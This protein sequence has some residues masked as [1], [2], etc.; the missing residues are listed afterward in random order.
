M[1]KQELLNSEKIELTTGEENYVLI[2]ESV[3][4]SYDDVPKQ[5]VDFRVNFDMNDFY[6]HG[7]V[8]RDLFSKLTNLDFIKEVDI[9]YEHG[10]GFVDLHGSVMFNS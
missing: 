1:K 3:F 10:E 9:T 7:R 5:V 2:T 4:N 6:D 8:A